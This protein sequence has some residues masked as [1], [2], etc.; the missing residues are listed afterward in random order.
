[1]L[2]STTS[3]EL[4][5]I[6]SRRNLIKAKRMHRFSSLSE[7]TTIF[8]LRIAVRHRRTAN[9]HFQTT[10]AVTFNLVIPNIKLFA[11][12][13][14]PIRRLLSC[15]GLGYTRSISNDRAYG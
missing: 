1:M 13:L 10:Q 4:L 7:E 9:L 11:I 5:Q 14:H 15:L 3:A 12:M 2:S 6:N 8:G